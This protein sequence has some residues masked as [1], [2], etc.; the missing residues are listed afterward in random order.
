[1]NMKQPRFARKAGWGNYC[2]PFKLQLLLLVLFVPFMQG[3]AL[4]RQGTEHLTIKLKNS[5][6]VAVFKAI[7]QQSSFKIFYLEKNLEGAQSVSINVMDA[8]I[9][10]VMDFIT[11]DQPFSY[12]IDASSVLI[13]RKA[14]TPTKTSPH[15]SSPGTD[16]SIV[17]GRVTS[18]KGD[19]LP[20]ATVKI[21]GKP[22]GV[23]TSSDG[24][25]AIRVP[26]GSKLIISYIG[27]QSQEFS[28]P[29]SGFKE[30]KLTESVNTLDESMV[31]AYGTTSKRYNTGNV[32]KVSA[33]VIASQPVSNPLSALEGRVA[34]L[35]VSESSGLPGAS[36]KVQLRGRNSIAQGNDPLFVVDGVPFAANNANI[37]QVGSALTTDK[38]GLSPFNSIS[39]S[40]IESI[41]VLKDADATAIYGSRGANGV[42]LITTKKGKAGKMKVDINANSG[43]S[44]VTRTAE[45]MDTKEYVAMRQEAFKNDN[46][47]PTVNNAYDIMLWDTTRQTNWTKKLIGG[48]AHMNQLQINLSGGSE[49]TQFLLGGNYMKQTTVF[50][51]DMADQRGA[52][53]FN[54]NH[55]ST[56]QKF[57]I[58]FSSSYSSDKNNLL[59]YD[60]ANFV[61][62]IPNFPEVRDA[63]GHLTWS[64]QG[65]PFD[66]PMAKIDQ[67]YLAATDNLISNLNLSYALM[68]KLT[69]KV[70]AGYNTMNVNEKSSTP[71]A[72]LNP[73]WYTSGSAAFGNK[74]LKSTII[75]PQLEFKGY[76]GGGKLNI[77]AGGS[78]QQSSSEGRYIYASGYSND[79]LLGSTSGASGLYVTDNNSMYR[80]AAIFGRINYALNEKYLVNVSARR[81]GSSRFG[82]GKQFA[83]FSAM[84]LGWIFSNENFIHEHL[85]VLSFG[86]LRMSYGSSGNDAIGDYQYLNT[87]SPTNYPYQGNASIYPTRLFN[88]DYSWEVNKKLEAA[89]EFGFFKDRLLLTTSFYR[90][91][92]NSQLVS[93]PLAAQTGFSSI[94]EN[95]NALV[96]NK[97]LELELT[98]VNI[99]TST[100]NWASSLNVTFPK[101]TL[102]SFPGLDQSSYASQYEIG[103]SLNIANGYPFAGVD[104]LT[105]LYEFF[106]SKGTPTSNPVYPGDYVKGLVNLDPK[107]YGGLRNLVDYKRWH[108]DLF[109]EFRK[110]V[111]TSVLNTISPPG[112]QSNYPTALLN[113]WS[114][115][116]DHSG[117]QKFTQSY[118]SDAY[119]VYAKLYDGS[120]LLFEDASYLRLKNLS[121]GY[122]MNE[123]WLKTWSASQCRVYIQ[124][125]NLL[126]F[127]HYRLGDPETQNIYR[128][129]PLKTIAAGAQITF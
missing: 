21:E 67:P 48:S 56:N 2:L 5:S 120:N 128:T 4:A 129:P 123:N 35:V 106:D 69:F 65:I 95:L 41:E 64:E 23:V 110:Q 103:K 62:T 39:P 15:R 126:T 79:A 24:S 37:N 53:H 22:G 99:K 72:T 77:L 44:K 90:N 113:R 40:D 85:Q 118:G 52:F 61:A 73:L 10:Q 68:S 50:P 63:V 1:M 34:G 114:K 31:I 93:Y 33:E 97:G 19:P 57:R 38:N 59:V 12:K 88:P 58:N 55:H 104:P 47:V 82:P 27:Y 76:L 117:V 42:I 25:Y 30:T 78:W 125:Q 100:F 46:Q 60:M 7:E 71:F 81:D 122:Q 96:E 66:N 127:T 54:I 124:C 102:V 9:Q 107:F 86:K 28:S 89:L 17:S 75:E 43:G 18:E 112:F 80:Y 92:S 91:R 98:S 32:S 111:G 116:G 94:I 3:K 108:F 87:Y 29:E 105:G 11:R 84:G 74:D 70:D 119:Q 26:K 121:I 83:N 14:V 8:T 13:S 6:V 51:G 49:T 36:L 101:N 20:G 16:T 115:I 109:I 45:M